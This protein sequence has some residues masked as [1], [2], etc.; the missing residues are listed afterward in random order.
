MTVFRHPKQFMS[1]IWF[2]KL[3]T[4]HIPNHVLLSYFDDL[5]NHC[6]KEP[7]NRILVDSHV[8]PGNTDSASLHIPLM[9]SHHPRIVFFNSSCSINLWCLVSF[10]QNLGLFVL[11]CIK[12]PAIRFDLK[13]FPH[14]KHFIQK[15]FHLNKFS[16]EYINLPPDRFFSLVDCRTLFGFRFKQVLSP[17]L[18]SPCHLSFSSLVIVSLSLLYF[19]HSYRLLCLIVPVRQKTQIFI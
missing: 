13:V 1:H 17:V 7:I 4:L 8:K 12:T 3:F 14:W 10:Y 19:V 6:H 11:S 5:S 15:T 16:P 18:S 9:S 2:H